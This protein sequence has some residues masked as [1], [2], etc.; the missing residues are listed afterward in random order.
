MDNVRKNPHQ[1]NLHWS[2][3]RQD[4]TCPECGGKTVLISAPDCWTIDYEDLN[5]D[6]YMTVEVHDEVTAHYCRDC[7]LMTALS[8]NTRR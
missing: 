6:D 8:L 5:S 4:T 3:E 2:P 1:T 7:C